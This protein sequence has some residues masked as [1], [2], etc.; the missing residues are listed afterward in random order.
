MGRHSRKKFQENVEKKVDLRR[1]LD[2]L[3]LFG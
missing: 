2:Q 3:I 1:G